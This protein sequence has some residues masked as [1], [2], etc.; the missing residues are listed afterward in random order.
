[1]SDLLTR[2][3]G[4]AVRAESPVEPILGSRYTPAAP[5]EV[6]PDAALMEPAQADFERRV[7]ARPE[8]HTQAEELPRIE[9][10]RET[11]GVE[12]GLRT[13][14]RRRRD[15]E[16]RDFPAPPDGIEPILR[17]TP[18][19][20]EILRAPAEAESMRAIQPRLRERSDG[21]REDHT[22]IEAVKTHAE[23]P[24]PAIERRLERIQET[25]RVE[26]IDRLENRRDPAPF[27]AESRSPELLPPVEVHVSIGHIEVRPAAPAPP[28]ARPVQKPHLTLDEYLRRRNG[29][30][31]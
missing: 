2:L 23:N 3:I 4:R 31:R 27:A 8:I 20:E 15:P 21:V 13:E 16:Q 6:P 1:M 12:D 17:Q 14:P 7:F 24:L 25:P 26:R 9:A 18:E 19:R 11:P 5:L 28:P 10:A 22:P 29:D 30:S